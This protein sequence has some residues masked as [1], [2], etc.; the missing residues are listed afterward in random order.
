M[1]PARCEPATPASDR[2]QTLVLDRSATGVGRFRSPDRPARSESLH[3]LSYQ[4]QKSGGK[5]QQLRKLQP[6]IRCYYGNHTGDDYIKR[7]RSN[8]GNLQNTY[9]ILENSMTNLKSYSSA[10]QTFFMEELLIQLHISGETPVSENS[11]RP[12]NVGSR[13]RNPITQTQCN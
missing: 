9:T 3:R 6:S 2:L 5:N 1:P 10:A 4:T 7:A 12:E 11:H 8:S 13:K